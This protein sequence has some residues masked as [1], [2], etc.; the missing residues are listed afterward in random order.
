MEAKAK[1]VCCLQTAE[2]DHLA[3]ICDVDFTQRKPRW[4]VP[5]FTSPFPRVPTM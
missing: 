2:N 5:V 4:F 3:A 1:T